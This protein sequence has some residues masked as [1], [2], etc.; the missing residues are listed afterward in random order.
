MKGGGNFLTRDFFSWEIGK[1]QGM[2]DAFSGLAGHK[3][4]LSGEFVSYKKN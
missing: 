2:V 3:T 4:S 1:G